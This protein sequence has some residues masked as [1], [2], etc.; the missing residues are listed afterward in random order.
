MSVENAYQCFTSDGSCH[1]CSSR[2][3]HY[4]HNLW[5]LEWATVMDMPIDRI[6]Y[7]TIVAW[8]LWSGYEILYNVADFVLRWMCLLCN[9]QYSDIY[10]Y[11]YIKHIIV[12]AYI[13]TLTPTIAQG[14]NAKKASCCISSKICANAYKFYK[15]FLTLRRNPFAAIAAL[16]H[17][18]TT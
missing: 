12:H 1:V 3:A 4:V 14:R 5:P 6:T 2:D 13:H 8:I 18:N 7:K 17:N 9:Q 10:I 16:F 11:I 15:F